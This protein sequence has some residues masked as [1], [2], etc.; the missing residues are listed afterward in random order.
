MA[1]H[2]DGVH[3]E[4][5]FTPPNSS[6]KSFVGLKL[7]FFNVSHPNYCTFRAA[8]HQG[9]AAIFGNMTKIGTSKTVGNKTKKDSGKL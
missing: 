9:A 5:H 2:N 3:S 6:G 7:G 1:T 4:L 8:Y